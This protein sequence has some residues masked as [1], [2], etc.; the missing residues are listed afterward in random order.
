VIVVVVNNEFDRK[1]AFDMLTSCWF[2]IVFCSSLKNLEKKNGVRE[3][4]G[5]LCVA[6]EQREEPE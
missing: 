3:M 6:S 1:N 2:I 5:T 4:K